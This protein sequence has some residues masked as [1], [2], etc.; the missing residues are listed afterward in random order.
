MTT[1]PKYVSDQAWREL[2]DAY[3]TWRRWLAAAKYKPGYEMRVIPNET[4]GC[5]YFEVRAQLWDS[6]KGREHVHFKRHMQTHV[7]NPTP[8]SMATGEETV[9]WEQRDWQVTTDAMLGDLVDIV[10]TKVVPPSMVY[11]SRDA[12]FEYVRSMLTDFE[13]HERDEWLR[14]DGALLH[15]PHAPLEPVAPLTHGSMA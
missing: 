1:E 6:T 9:S 11:A 15:D 14:V 2:H 8:L 12:F 13:L 7:Q 5:V 10:L 3:L 4:L